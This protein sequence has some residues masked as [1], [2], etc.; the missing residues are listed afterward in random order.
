LE[1]QGKESHGGTYSLGD[2]I[3]DLVCG[4]LQVEE[5][6]AEVAVP[7]GVG[8]PAPSPVLRDSQ[9]PSF[10]VSLSPTRKEEL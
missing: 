7:G 6:A 9:H 2:G 8:R 5:G 1:R 4:G 3:E 10:S